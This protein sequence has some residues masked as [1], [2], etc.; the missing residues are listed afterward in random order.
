MG[1]EERRDIRVPDRMMQEW[2]E[3]KELSSQRVEVVDELLTPKMQRVPEYMGK[4][5]EF[6]E[7]YMPQLI[8]IGPIHY[9]KHI[10]HQGKPYKYKW[11]AMYLEGTDRTIDAL[12]RTISSQFRELRQQFTEDS[13]NEHLKPYGDDGIAS[14][15]W[16]LVLDGCSILQV[17]KKSYSADPEQE[18]EISIDKL[19][20]VHQ[21][22]L[23]LENQ[24]PFKVLKLLCKDDLK[25]CL[26]NFLQIHGVKMA[27]APSTG[28]PDLGKEKKNKSALG[29]AVG[30]HKVIVQA[31]DH[32]LNEEDPVHLLDYLRR[33]LLMRD[34]GQIHK[35]V[36]VNKKSLHLKKY[37]IGTIREL[38]AAGIR[39]RKDPDNNSFYPSFD[40]GILRLPELIVDGSMAVIFL[41]LIAYEMCPDFRNDLEISSYVVFM[42]SLIDQPEDVKELRSAGILINELA[43]DKEVADLFNKMDSILVPERP[44]F[45]HI[46]DQIHMHFESKRGKIKML[47]WMGEAYNSCFRS[48]WTIIA[49]LAASLGLV[50]T[51]IQTW[52]SIHPKVP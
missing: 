21:D 13:W 35:E 18:L 33:A 10:W 41:N 12:F 32:Q 24:I 52:F 45:A 40:H 27:P 20:R 25:E 30:E 16:M 43:S 14:A 42:S 29:Q 15:S 47:G 48:P 5:V 9:K 28:K 39:V 38:K 3:F 11:T 31:D 26:S 49:L 51:F 6:S 50:L 34:L 17:L 23:L 37:R 8:T 1:S 4:R 36:K 7:L 46:R 2:F 22:L 44:R 19:I